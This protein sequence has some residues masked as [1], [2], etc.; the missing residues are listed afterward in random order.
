[1]R[2]HGAGVRIPPNSLMS[3]RM[4]RWCLARAI[5]ISTPSSVISLD[6]Q[7]SEVGKEI[8]LKEVQMTAAKSR[9]SPRRTDDR[10][11]DDYADGSGSGR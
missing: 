11:R 5:A 1:V 9:K 2:S 3:E 4:S 8:C 7:L 10:D 6:V